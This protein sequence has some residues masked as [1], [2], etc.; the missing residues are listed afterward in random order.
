MSEHTTLIAMSCG[1]GFFVLI[2]IT[3][4]LWAIITPESKKENAPNWAYIL[5]A[6]LS[7]IIV[8]IIVTHL[9]LNLCTN[10]KLYFTVPYTEEVECELYKLMKEDPVVRT[11]LLKV[12]GTDREGVHMF[13]LSTKIREQ[14]KL[15]GILDDKIDFKIFDS[16][17]DAVID[18]CNEKQ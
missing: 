2:L 11:D 9:N 16:F 13:H 14:D 7:T 10:N 4:L 17:E 5:I 15:M 8:G 6:I 18:L 1:L 3:F 12:Y